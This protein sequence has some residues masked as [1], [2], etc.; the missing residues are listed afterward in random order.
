RLAEQQVDQRLV[1]RLVALELSDVEVPPPAAATTASETP[2][3]YVRIIADDKKMTVELW[4]RGQLQGLRRLSLQ[5]SQL[6]RARRIALAS[7]VLVRQ[8]RERRLFENEEHQRRLAA[9]TKRLSQPQPPTIA[10]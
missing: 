8:L 7:G 2:G 3:L 1:Q 10:A 6:L 5:G 4:D 9:E